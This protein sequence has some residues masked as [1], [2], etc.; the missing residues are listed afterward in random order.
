MSQTS[1]TLN[2][3]R[4]FVILIVLAFHS[5][6]AYLFSLPATAFPFDEP[7]YKWLA[8]PIVDGHR[9]VGFDLFCAFQ[10]VYLMSFMFL[11]SG[12]F[13]WPSLARKGSRK[14]LQDRLVRLG[15]PFV[16]V[17][18]LLMP[19][20][21]YPIYRA[22]A[23]DPSVAAFWQHWLV[24]PFW[25][26]GPT[27]FLIQLLLL[28]IVAAILHRFAP[29]TGAILGRLASTARTDPIRFFIGLV[30]LSAVAYVP[31]AVAFT[32]WEWW[33]SGPIALQLSRPLHYAV[34]FFAGV[35][36][37]AYG[38]ERG[39]LAADGI[40]AQHWKT[41]LAAAAVAFLTWI[42]ATALT[43]PEGAIV[44]LWLQ[45]ASDIAFVLSCATGCFFIA[46]VFLRY[47]RSR[48]RVLDSLSANAYGIYLIHFVF[49][50]WL[51]YALL[52]VPLFA[53]A[54]ATIVFCVAMPLSWGLVAALRR[55]PFST[56]LLGDGQP[57]LASPSHASTHSGLL[58]E[59]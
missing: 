5:S 39:L 44:P 25:P 54:K 19:V 43:M 11:L 46:A 1:L 17:V 32:P 20:A 28:D 27:W 3:L 24:L 15:L 4:A 21:H 55:I 45:L 26:D 9:W 30:A 10:D 16:V 33:E 18:Y 48:S 59:S 42:G 14:F 29:G 53:I 58:L 51:Q 22:T 52:D 36:I 12:L 34:Y 49:T 56:R 37:G 7:P 57:A 6:L 40:L 8:F 47:S 23:D 41:W 2:N 35:G 13:V 38:I 50:V 31:L